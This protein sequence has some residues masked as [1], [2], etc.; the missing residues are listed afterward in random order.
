MR[1]T[2]RAITLPRSAAAVLALTAIV[3]GPIRAQA[4][5]TSEARGAWGGKTNG[6]G[7]YADINGL[8]LYYEIHGEG[9]PIILL[10]GGLGAIEMFGPNLAAL[11]EGHQVIALD[12]QGHG[13]TADID[14]PISVELM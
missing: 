8:K 3:A 7:H 10:H 9:K 11:A 1:S 5:A 14:R 2:S 6:Q 4:Q 12:L 13:R